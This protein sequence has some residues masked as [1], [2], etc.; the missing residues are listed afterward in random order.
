M[1]P[2]AHCPLAASPSFSEFDVA[3]KEKNDSIQHSRCERM[4][5]R[6]S[7]YAEM[8]PARSLGYRWTSSMLS[9][10]IASSASSERLPTPV[11]SAQPGFLLYCPV[12]D[13]DMGCGLVGS[14]SLTE[15]VPLIVP[16]LPGENCTCTVQLLFG[17]RLSGQLFAETTKLALA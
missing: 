16:F 10:N 6:H 4:S 17:S 8:H 7:I 5:L 14:L 3:T 9:R 13:S 1:T 2:R 15:R 12:P 11:R